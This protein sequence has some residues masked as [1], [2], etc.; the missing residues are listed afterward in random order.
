MPE[1]DFRCK[2]CAHRFAASVQDLRR[3]YEAATLQ[4]PA[5]QI[6]GDL[7][8]LISQ[9]SQL[10]KANRDYQQDVFS[11]RCYRCWS[12]ASRGQ[13]DMMFKQVGGKIKTLMLPSASSQPAD[14]ADPD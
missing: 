1:Y 12:R 14:S 8:R 10:P 13:V 4:C 2:A 9:C 6:V 7:S 5:L 11:A 3:T